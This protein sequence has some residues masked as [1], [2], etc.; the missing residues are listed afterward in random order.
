[1]SNPKRETVRVTDHAVLRY[2]ERAMGFDVEGV[3]SHIRDTCEP[4]ASVEATALRADGVKF[5][6]TNNTV[7]TTLPDG[8]GPSRTAQQRMQRKLEARV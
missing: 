6:I 1:M 4:S 5:V 7:T 3:R 2:L 8:A